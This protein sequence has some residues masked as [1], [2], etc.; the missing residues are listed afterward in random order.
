MRDD[1]ISE[2][3]ASYLLEIDN[4]KSQSKNLSNKIIILKLQN[5]A[6]NE[7]IDEYISE[8][9]ITKE[10]FNQAETE[11]Q[12]T[13]S[14]NIWEIG[15]SVPLPS[16]PTNIK[17]YTDYRFYNIDGTPHKRLQSVAWTDELGCRRYN[18]D[19]IVALGSFYST[20]IGDRFEITLDTGNV[21]TVILGDGKADIDTD[22]NNMYAPC[23]NYNGE[24]CANVLEFIVDKNILSDK[25]YNY[26][27]VDYYDKLKG[28]IIKMTYLGRDTTI[29]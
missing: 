24:A 1:E 23:T 26:G 5:V 17:S 10:E 2:L 18:N 20:D 7:I 3:N 29:L 11:N 4:I 8:T 15:E 9:T 25:A 19:Y 16:L 12:V 6:L 28:N 22:V 13:T 21:F 27:S 14:K